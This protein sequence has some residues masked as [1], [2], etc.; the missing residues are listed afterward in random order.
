MRSPDLPRA[1]LDLPLAHRGLH[2]S[3]NGCIENSLSAVASAVDAGY[4]IEIDVQL[5]ACGEAMVFHDGTLDRLTQET[6]PLRVRTAL[7]LETL[8]LRDSSDTVPRLTSVLEAVAGDVPLL[9]EIKDQDGALGK[10]VGPLECRVAACLQTYSGPVAVMSM[11]PFAVAAFAAHAPKGIAWGLTT[12]AFPA[13]RWPD[14]PEQ[15]RLALANIISKKEIG[16]S[17]ISHDWL[18]LESTAVVAERANGTP[19]LCWT[20]R[21]LAEE[22]RARHHCDNITFE[23]Y[24][25]EKIS[26]PDSIASAQSGTAT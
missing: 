18:D 19:V 3:T 23:G 16:A 9:I 4:G 15:R 25:P 14:V 6:G 24:Q 13:V 12:S 17:F 22:V 20:V 2:D 10:R 7:E 21:S 11:N 1:F 26:S 8:E 5:A